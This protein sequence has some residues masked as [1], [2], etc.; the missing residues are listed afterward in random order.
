MKLSGFSYHCKQGFLPAC[1]FCT[2][3]F[4]R[5]A[6]Q[7]VFAINVLPILTVSLRVQGMVDAR[8]IWGADP[9]VFQEL[10]IKAD[11]R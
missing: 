4:V 3:K 2:T 11:S 6:S 5:M 9:P 10:G 1:I 8:R 7:R